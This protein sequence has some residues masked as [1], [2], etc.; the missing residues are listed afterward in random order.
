MVFCALCAIASEEYLASPIQIG[1]L[2]AGRTVTVTFNATVDVQA[3]QL[4]VNPTNTGQVKTAKDGSEEERRRDYT[5]SITVDAGK[6][7]AV[8]AKEIGRRLLPD[9]LTAFG[10]AKGV[11]HARKHLAAYATAGVQ[12]EQ[13]N[14]W[15]REL[16][17]SDDPR[18]V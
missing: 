10:V 7:A 3:N 13:A 8:I 2:P 18:A 12:S 11:R 5:T 6:P 14:V 9:Y 16:L 15:R 4:I 17:V 1:T